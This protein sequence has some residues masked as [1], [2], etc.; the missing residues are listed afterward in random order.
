MGKK[1][2]Q[3]NRKRLRLA[4]ISAVISITLVLFILGL[5]GLTLISAQK[6]SNYVKESLSMELFL[7]DNVTESEANM[8]VGKLKNKTYTKSAL[9]ISKDK[10][11]DTFVRLYGEDFNDFIDFNPLLASVQLNLK[12]EY[13]D[14]EK[15]SNIEK[16]LMSEFGES[17]V[18]ITKQKE[19]ITSVNKN[20]QSIGVGLLAFS[21]ILLIIVIAL[22]NNTIRLSIYAKRFLIKTMQLVGAKPSFIRKP[23]VFSGILQG[24]ISAFFSILLLALVIYRIMDAFPGFFVEED[25]MVLLTL[26][27]SV[28][29]VGILLT[30]IS[31]WFAVRKFLNLRIDD[32]Y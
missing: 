20:L 30:S 32:L 4:Y 28:I 5:V 2:E 21:G 18:E 23:F 29:L 19:L 3:F 9:Y 15:I 13:V 25:L 8:L 11:K 1:E 12:A 31:T 24:L 6:L 14:G 27:F 7:N 26:F 10:A 16:E 17:I 22:I